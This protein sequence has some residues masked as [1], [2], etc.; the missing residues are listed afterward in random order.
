MRIGAD[1]IIMTRSGFVPLSKVLLQGLYVNKAAIS[2]K[3]EPAINAAVNTYGSNYGWDCYGPYSHTLDSWNGI[4]GT[5]GY[6]FS[7][8]FSTKSQKVYEVSV[9]DYTNGRAYR[10]INPKFIAKHR[11]EALARNV[12]PNEAWDEV[13]Y[14]DLD[15]DDDFIQK[16]L[17]IREGEDYDTRVQ[18]PVDFS[19]EDLLKYMKMAHDRDMTFNEFVEDALRHALDEIKAGRLNVSNSPAFITANKHEN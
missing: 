10:M 13:D 1:L 7:I 4:H 15:V 9:C 18:V 12:N 19:D 6:S 17:A 14:I 5:G 8:I 3:I 11:K 16:C 2:N